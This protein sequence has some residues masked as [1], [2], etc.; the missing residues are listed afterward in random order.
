MCGKIINKLKKWIENYFIVIVKEEG[1]IDME[2][3]PITDSL[4]GSFKEPDNFDYKKE[5]TGALSDKYL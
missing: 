5:L 4:Q 3:A 2:A 1:I